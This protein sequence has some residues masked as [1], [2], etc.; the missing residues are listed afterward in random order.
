MLSGEVLGRAVLLWGAFLGLKAL[1]ALFVFPPLQS[2]SVWLPSGLTLAV[3]LR[4]EKRRWPVYLVAIF[5][6][7]FMLVPIY[8]DPWDMALFWAL[9]NCLRTVVG[10]G[11]MRRW[12]DPPV[13]FSRPR[14]VAA[15]LIAGGL[16]S[17][18]PSATLGMGAVALLGDVDSFWQGWGAWYLSDGLGAVLI[19]P[20][21]LTWKR[22]G[23]WPRRPWDIAELVGMLGVLAL[24]AHVT[25][26]VLSPRGALLSL[27]YACLPF[28][29]WAAL[30]Q[31]PR[32]AASA[33]LVLGTFAVIHTT[34]GRGPFG[35]LPATLIERVLSVQVFLAVASL[36]TLT[37]AALACERR[38]VERSQRVL[39]EAGAVLAES[40]NPRDTLPRLA[41]LVVPELASGFILWLAD[42]DG[43][44]VTAVR[45][46]VPPELEVRLGEAVR[47]LSVPSRRCLEPEGAVVLA[48]M[49]HRGRLLGGMALVQLGRTHLPR[50]RAASFAEDLAHHCALSLENARL[51][52]ESQRA[53]L[54][55]DEFI[56]VAAHEL[57]TPLTSLKLQLQ[58]LA[59]LLQPLPDAEPVLSRFHGVVRQLSR[60]GRLVESLLDVR[61][62]H[63]GQFQL[64]RE[65]VDLVELVQ[66][67][68]AHVAPDL[69]RAG[70][71]V[72][73]KVQSHVTGVWDR[74]QLEQALTHLLANAMKFG[75]GHPIEL[76]VEQ[77]E[78]L[79]R[80]LVRDH[81]IGVAPEALE[82]IFGRFERAVSVREYGG[83]GLGL[84]LTRQIIEAHG[85]TIQATGRPGEGATFIL[86]L[87]ASPPPPGYATE[88]APASWPVSP[89]E[90]SHPT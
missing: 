7:E 83:L 35:V 89:P 75:A 10:A 12:V 9:G 85:G 4:A 21:L 15:L 8:G 80:L 65:S 49:Q 54:T 26:G 39:A 45:T 57:R 78:G 29:I 37:L 14:D 76:E 67:V 32:G 69:A 40:M 41:R 88:S 52:E 77:R 23:S 5:L 68:V 53:V 70:C 59:R 62:L 64:Q 28:V 87:P 74:T 61:R 66:D 24:A 33:A 79:A 84:F 82:R 46:G 25:F 36:S 48:R 51:L 3:F 20:V 81:G 71:E 73:L 50:A 86:Q 43:R 27:P 22:E 34:R 60:L 11:L 30:R 17:P 63:T 31:G 38:R 90:G 58:G 2:A 16:I 56:T 55:R 18:L 47:R 42:E 19:A 44:F 1:S 72:S 6:A 13:N